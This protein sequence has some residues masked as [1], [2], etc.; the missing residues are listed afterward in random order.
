MVEH[1]LVLLNNMFVCLLDKYVRITNVSII[2][3]GIYTCGT[4]VLLWWL[5]KG[6]TKCCSNNKKISLEGTYLHKY[7]RIVL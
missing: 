1:Q 5:Y 7:V 6:I 3:L 4:S 2:V